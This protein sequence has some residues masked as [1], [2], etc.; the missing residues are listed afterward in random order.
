M[1]TKLRIQA[2][3][4]FFLLS[5]I[6]FCW[7]FCLSYFAYNA[8]RIDL[9]KNDG[10][11]LF[12]FKEEGK[13]LKYLVSRCLQTAR[14]SIFISSFGITDKEIGKMLASTPLPLKIAF[15]AKEK[16]L[17]PQG[18]NVS[19]FPY[20]KKSGLM[21]RKVIG[22]DC[23]LLLLG[24]TNLT[25]LALKIHKNLIV[26][27]RSKALYSAILENKFLQ[28]DSF[29]YYPLPETGKVALQT[30]I[31][32][33]ASAKHRIFICMYTFT[34]PKIIEALMDA[35]AR[36]ID[37]QV[38]LDRG[39]ACGTCKK[40]SALLYPLVKT[41]LGGGLLHHKCALIDNTF[42][43]GSANWSKAAFTKNEEYLLFLPT[44]PLRT[45]EQFFSHLEK[46]STSQK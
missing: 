15:D 36:G 16:N 12:Y 35:Y 43:F 44:P 23:E 10:E 5:L 24:S 39:M 13:D 46:T 27:I 25:P 20:I 40:A 37:V 1:T 17:L 38:Y 2:L 21:H 28:T 4:R 3:F 14:E 33:I 6:V 30:L 26:C 32:T 8:L 19:L 42:I 22:I 11:Y 41:H 31:Q 45:L 34:H 9:P 7:L 29:S 18:D